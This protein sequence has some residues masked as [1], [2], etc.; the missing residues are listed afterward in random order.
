[1]DEEL[2][3]NI[4]KF[5]EIDDKL[6]E[7][8]KEITELKEQQEACKDKILEYM[9][10]NEIPYIPTSKG[11]LKFKKYNVM[12]KLDQD[13]VVEKLSSVLPDK[14]TAIRAATHLF[15]SREKTEKITLK[16]TKH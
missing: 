3:V 14:N 12:S 1:M 2:K 15:E 7:R 9:E 5:I 16:R 10:A 11:K 8:R 6:K 13:F 4:K